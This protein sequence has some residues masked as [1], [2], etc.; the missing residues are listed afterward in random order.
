MDLEERVLQQLE[1]CVLSTT[2]ELYQFRPPVG[3]ESTIQG[4]NDHNSH[5]I[6]SPPIF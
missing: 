6:A 1:F 4:L 2:P 5:V 3:V